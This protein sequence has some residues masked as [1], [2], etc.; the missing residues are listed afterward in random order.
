MTNTKTF[1]VF[2]EDYRESFWNYMRDK[3]YNS[4]NLFHGVS[5]M[6]AY[7]I[8][9]TEK[10]PFKASLKKHSVFREISN[11]F[12]KKKSGSYIAV[13]DCNDW[14][15][16]IGEDDEI[17]LK[18]A[19]SDYTEERF[20]LYKIAAL[21]KLP[22][23][24]VNDAKFD[25]E[26]NISVRLGKSFAK[27]E[28]YAFTLGNGVKMPVGILNDEGGAEV[29]VTTKTL[30][31]DDVIKLYFSV[32]PEYRKNGAWMMNDETA[33]AL[34]ALKDADGNYVWNHS[35]DT[36]LGKKVVINE[37]MPGVSEGAKPIAFGDFGYFCIVEISN[38]TMKVIKEVLPKFDDVG[39]LA[40]EFLDAKLMR[41]EAIKV[42]K[43]TK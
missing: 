2:S 6:G 32:K 39:Y 21:C 12:A 42:L 35:A 13:Q 23:N 20:N 7:E 38:A 43:I 10:S 18:D 16:W 15:G 28:T 26:K 22:E 1:G 19:A 37:Y 25:V 17:P 36:I 41:P 3:K 5:N 33:L 30:T 24:F 34:R 31:Y 4:D 27:A 11:V 9:L 8:P 40:F 14:A 29:G